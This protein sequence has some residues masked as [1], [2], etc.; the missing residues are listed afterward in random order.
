M[1]TATSGSHPSRKAAA[2]SYFPMASSLPAP[3]L[4]H[5]GRAQERLP[6]QLLRAGPPGGRPC[7]LVAPGRALPVARRRLYPGLDQGRHSLARGDRSSPR[8][9]RPPAAE[10]RLPDERPHLLA[11]AGIAPRPGTEHAHAVAPVD[12]ARRRR[13]RPMARVLVEGLGAVDDQGVPHG[14]REMVVALEGRLAIH[15]QASGGFDPARVV[16]ADPGRGRK[17]QDDHPV[18]NRRADVTLSV[19]DREPD[20]AIE[21]GQVR[22]FPLGR[23]DRPSVRC[24]SGCSAAR[25]PRCGRPPGR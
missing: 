23:P 2:S 13:H 6:D 17:S 10:H 18:D 24:P 4:R 21:N 25:I 22:R 1:P 20:H 11:P 9:R 15:D 7:R 3:A 5:P 12:A 16:G 8:L 14:E 19:V